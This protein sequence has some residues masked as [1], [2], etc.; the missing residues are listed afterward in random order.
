MTRLIVANLTNTFKKCFDWLKMSIYFYWKINLILFSMTL[1]WKFEH[2][3]SSAS[4]I[5]LFSTIFWL[6]LIMS[7]MTDKKKFEYRTDYFD[8]KSSI[9]SNQK[10]QIDQYDFNRQKTTFNYTSYNNS[11]NNSLNCSNR[12]SQFFYQLFYQ[13]R[14]S[15]N[16]AYNNQQYTQQQSCQ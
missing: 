12:N 9:K 3:T 16:N 13:P 8:N 1:I 4:R 7:N 5:I 11:T 15:Q 2:L 10:Q 6:N 14:Y